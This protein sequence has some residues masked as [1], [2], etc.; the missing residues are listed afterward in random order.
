[1]I[2]LARVKICMV[3]ICQVLLVYDWAVQYS[4]MDKHTR[5]AAR[6]MYFGRI[7]E[8]LD[9]SA[10]DMTRYFQLFFNFLVS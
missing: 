2:L 6:Y 4:G 5:R 1:M 3:A 9:D 7:T 8:D 10:E